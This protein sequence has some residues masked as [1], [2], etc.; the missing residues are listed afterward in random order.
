MFAMTV[1]YRARLS[2]LRVAFK[3]M[4]GDKPTTAI[5][6]DSSMQLCKMIAGLGLKKVMIVTDKPLLELGMIDGVRAR[7]EELGVTVAVY[8]GVQPDPTL[9]VVREGIAV[10]RENNSD[11]ILAV[12]GGSSIDAAKVMS[13]CIANNKEP[14]QVIGILKGNKPALPFFVIPTTAGT[15]SETTIGAVISDDITHRKD[16]VINPKLIPVAAA[17]DPVMMKKL[18]AS[19]TAATGMDALTHAIESYISTFATQDSRFYSAAAT[20]MVLENLPK[21]CG[22][23]SEN[24]E[25]RENMAVASYYA[26]LAISKAHVGYVHA[27]AHQLGAKYQIPHGLAN[28]VVLPQILE[29]SKESARQPLAELARIAGIGELSMS[30]EQLTQALIDHIKQLN[31]DLGIPAALDNIKRQDIPELASAA[32]KEGNGY[33]VPVFIDRQQCEGVIA[34]VANI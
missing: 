2:V 32:L 19:I 17:L 10:A 1:L 7:L 25:V 28:A 27:I 22:K 34:R 26:G 29:I 9:S 14:H 5:G 8:D 15:G 30:D 18:P 23:E 16:L 31:S 4:G 24:L 21:A 33:P 6:P 3:L 20:R 11:A 12:G 13:L